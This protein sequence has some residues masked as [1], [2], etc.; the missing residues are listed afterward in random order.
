MNTITAAYTKNLTVPAIILR[1][2]D[3]NRMGPITG[4]L[5]CHP[6]GDTHECPSGRHFHN[7][8]DHHFS[9]CHADHDV[10]LHPVPEMVI[11]VHSAEIEGSLRSRLNSRVQFPA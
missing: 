4:Y 5:G 9:S 3:P 8:S 7:E 11:G 2:R 6:A 10:G 1:R